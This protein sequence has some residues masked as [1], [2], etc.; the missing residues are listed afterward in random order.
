MLPTALSVMPTL[1]LVLNAGSSSLKFAVY[2]FEREPVLECRGVLAGIGGEV[3]ASTE[4]FAR[5][6]AKRVLLGPLTL[7]AAVHWVSDWYR[8][9]YG[10]ESPTFV[11]H[12]VVHGGAHFQEAT[13]VTP[14]VRQALEALIVWAPLHQPLCLAVMDA[15]AELWP[16]AK[17]VACFDT[18]FHSVQPRRARLYA[19]PRRW[20]E[21]GVMRYG[22]HGLSFASVFRQ[23]CA[24]APELAHRKWVVAHLGS[25]S[26][27]CAIEGGLSVATTMGLSPLEGVPMTTRCGSVDPGVLLYLLRQ[28]GIDVESLEHLLYRESGLFGLSGI[29]GDF[30][31]LASSELPEAR[32]A[33]DLFVYR[34][35]REVASLVGA[36][37][38]LDVLVFTG[39]IGENASNIRKQI[40]EGLNWLGVEI[41]PEANAL[42]QG[43]ISRPGSRVSVWVVRSDENGE[44]A[45]QAWALVGD[46]RSV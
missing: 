38:G 22:F 30:R 31:A 3:E 15:A 8:H 41:D 33:I 34:V 36:L 28:P 10:N 39:G 11:V 13:F 20:V 24:T 32:E 37:R 43:C 40:C 25:G 44:M 35:Q 14:E 19:L 21:A 42:G 6:Q 46:S 16:K 18:A 27:L 7:N 29:S 4:N 9:C 23:L 17:A 26:S 45:R 12:R 2:R 1:L 5:G